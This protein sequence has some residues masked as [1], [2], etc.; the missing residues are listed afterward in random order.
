MILFVSEPLTDQAVYVCL[1]SRG[2]VREKAWKSGLLLNT[3]RANSCFNDDAGSFYRSGGF[4]MAFI[5]C[6]LSS[7]S[8]AKLE[9]ISG[10]RTQRLGKV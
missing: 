9:K 5:I 3:L 7:W 2:D 1:I 6:S 10:A 4:C 8:S